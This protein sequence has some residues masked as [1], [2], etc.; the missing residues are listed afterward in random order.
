MV[1]LDLGKRIMKLTILVLLRTKYVYKYIYSYFS[2]ELY[3]FRTIQ[4]SLKNVFGKFQNFLEYLLDDAVSLFLHTI[5][6]RFVKNYF[7]FAI[8]SFDLKVF[9]TAIY[10]C[11]YCNYF[12]FSFLI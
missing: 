8:A 5:D 11:S 3:H 9:A 2:S 4:R 10:S 12:L 1:D 6:A 7:R